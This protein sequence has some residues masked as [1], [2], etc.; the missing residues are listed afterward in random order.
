MNFINIWCNCILTNISV[1]VK[2]YKNCKSNGET[3]EVYSKDLIVTNQSQINL[4]ADLGNSEI[5]KTQNSKYVLSKEF[6]FRFFFWSKFS[7]SF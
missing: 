5:L 7:G 1:I 2:R 6:Y 3:E 4:E